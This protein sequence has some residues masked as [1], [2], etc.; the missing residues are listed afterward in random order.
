M[1]TFVAEY[2]NTFFKKHKIT[3]KRFCELTDV[4]EPTIKSLKAKGFYPSFETLKKIIDVFPDFAL[5]AGFSEDSEVEASTPEGAPYF[6]VGFTAGWSD[7]AESMSYYI[8]FPP[9]AVVGD[10]I[11]V[12]QVGDAM[13][14]RIM[15]GDKIALI[16]RGVSSI[17]VGK[18]YGVVAS[19]GLRLLA[20]AARSPIEGNL[21]FIPENKEPKHG[22]YHDV[23]EKDIIEVYEVVG[24]LRSF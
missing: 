15:P 12:N 1:K 2:F 11:W 4:P 13:S 3:Q 7:L 20:W 17:S 8:N 23:P 6:D 24:L 22:E 21:R 10:I 16:K 18:I 9:F 5:M 19:T 14:P